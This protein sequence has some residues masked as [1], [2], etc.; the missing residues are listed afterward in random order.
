M[1]VI[2]CR[3][4]V[5]VLLVSIWVMRQTDMKCSHTFVS[6]RRASRIR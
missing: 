1:R 4:G 2:M 6:K 5:P 3:T